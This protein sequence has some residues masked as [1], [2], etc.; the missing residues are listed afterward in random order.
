[1]RVGTER[2]ENQFIIFLSLCFVFIA[3][4]VKT[5]L[6]TRGPIISLAKSKKWKVTSGQAMTL[7]SEQEEVR[8]VLN[9]GE[10]E[11]I[12]NGRK[13]ITQP[14]LTVESTPTKE[15]P[16]WSFHLFEKMVEFPQGEEPETY[17]NSLQKYKVNVVT[18]EIEKTY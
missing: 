12:V 14:K 6:P 10:S 16:Y 5:V 13:V 17:I 18:G 1:M 11:E 2:R 7:V 9:R 15:D 8:A 4:F 3:L